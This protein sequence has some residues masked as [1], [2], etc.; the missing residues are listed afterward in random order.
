MTDVGRKLEALR[1]V[2]ILHCLLWIANPLCLPHL[3]HSPTSNTAPL[4]A[5]VGCLHALGRMELRTSFIP[6]Y[7]D[8][9]N[10]SLRV[11]FN[12]PHF[13]LLGCKWR[14]RVCCPIISAIY[15]C[16]LG[17]L[18]PS[19]RCSMCPVNKWVVQICKDFCSLIISQSLPHPS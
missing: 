9:S 18:L 14:W 3:F 16:Q 10:F 2:A 4:L 19:L 11:A 5:S 15:H 8:L 7:K 6:R 13:F 1:P 12:S 17:C